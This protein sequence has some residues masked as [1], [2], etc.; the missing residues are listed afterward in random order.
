ML[1]TL[2][3]RKSK[4]TLI[5]KLPGRH[6]H[7]LA[8]TVRDMLCRHKQK[9]LTI[10]AD[11]GTE[12]AA[13]KLIARLTGTQVYFAHPYCSFERCLNENTNGLIRQYIPKSRKEETVST[14]EIRDIQDKLNDRSRKTLDF[15]TPREIFFNDTSVAHQG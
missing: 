5:R 3:E 7:R 15:L 1:V 14:W 13:H 2:V 11:N 4:F 6:A 9:S 10:T 8:R 12:F